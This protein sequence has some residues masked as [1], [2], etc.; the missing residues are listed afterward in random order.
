VKAEVL[1][2]A[3][4]VFAPSSASAAPDPAKGEAVYQDRCSLC[5]QIEGVGQGPALKGVVGRKAGTVEGFNYTPAL[6]ASGL[7]WTPTVLDK[8]LT[9]PDKMVP[10][11]AMSMTAP[12]DA[13]RADLI[14]YLE[15]QK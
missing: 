8:F 7:I 12:D 1:L 9:G 13:D 4:V 5:H 2:S 6:K 11:A 14:A 15:T 10:G 3:F